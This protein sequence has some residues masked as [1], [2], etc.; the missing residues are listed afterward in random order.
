MSLRDSMRAVWVSIETR[1]AHAAKDIE[2]MYS[3][4]V[5]LIGLAPQS[6]IAHLNLAQAYF[7]RNEFENSVRAFSDAEFHSSTAEL[8]FMAR[9]GR[10]AAYGEKQQVDEALAAYQ[11]ALEIDPN[12]IETKTNIELLV[13]NQNQQSD[14]N[15]D[16]QSK[17]GSQGDQKNDSKK[18]S[19]GDSKDQN[20]SSQKN[21]DKNDQKNNNEP[22]KI[23]SGRQKP[24]QEF[25]SKELSQKD[26]DKILGEL[27]SQEQK[28]RQ[29]YFRRERKEMPNGKDW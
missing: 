19:T 29:Q 1:K 8:Q 4:S 9:F 25:S 11:S 23:E 24:K 15:K 13:Q 16:S 2:K 18:D 5:E 20:E 28:V 14:K 3:K 10:G 26:V 7:L 6:A 17:D 27:E 22:R 21:Q 12:N